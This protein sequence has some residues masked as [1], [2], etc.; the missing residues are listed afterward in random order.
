MTTT[1][2]GGMPDLPDFLDR[3]KGR[4]E[5]EIDD[6]RRALNA[7]AA[8]APEIRSTAAAKASAPVSP[9]VE[10]P[11][12]IKREQGRIR[13]E[14]LKTVKSNATEAMPLSG[15]EALR[16]IAEEPAEPTQGAEQPDMAQGTG[17]VR[18][19]A[20]RRALA[21]T[22]RVDEVKK[23]HDQ[24]MAL[25]VYAKQAKDNQLIDMATEIRMRA[26]IRAGELLAEMKVCGERV[27]SKDMLKK[28]R[29]SS[30]Q[31]R[32]PKLSDLGVT[33]T[34]SSRWQQLAALPKEEQEEKIRAAKRKAEAAVEPPAKTPRAT[35]SAKS[36]L[37]TPKPKP[38]IQPA[39]E[40]R[41]VPEVIAVDELAVLRE[42]ALFVL[43][44][45]SVRVDPKD[46][47]RWKV[48]SGQVR[49]IVEG[50]H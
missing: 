14:K 34:Q 29:G 37:T 48:L 20:A 5:E 41:V 24:A 45:A 49:M 4:A 18:Y 6:E 43:N 46:S 50:Q 36:K 27:A 42:F 7:K 44:T 15:K 3:T 28:G 31:P 22:H 11:K 47:D 12:E 38:V 33:K 9:I 32:E 1:D 19:E 21:E 40:E 30:V 2:D 25:Q 16:K 17:L 39:P 8:A 10:H 26:E 23:I 35:K 13:I